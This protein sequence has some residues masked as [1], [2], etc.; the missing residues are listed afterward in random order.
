MSNKEHS[1][2][3]PSTSNANH[4]TCL[5]AK[6]SLDCASF[7]VFWTDSTA[8]LLYVNEAAS[9][10]FGYSRDEFFS[11]NIFDLAPDFKA[12][13]WPRLW[14]KLKIKRRMV[15]QGAARKKDGTLFAGEVT[16]NYFE[17]DGK[18][19][20]LVFFMDITERQSAEEE[21]HYEKSL[22]DSVINALPGIFYFFDEDGRFIFWNKNVE[23]I[24]GYGADELQ[25]LNAF[26]LI[27]GGDR[28]RIKKAIQDVFLNGRATIDTEILSKDGRNIPYYFQG[29]RFEAGGKRYVLGSGI[30]MTEQKWIEDELKKKERFLSDIFNSIQDGISVSDKDMR[31]IRVNPIMEK[32]YPHAQPMIGRKCWE[33]YHGRQTPCEVCPVVKT[34]KTKKTEY[35]VVPW[36]DADGTII[37]WFDLY[38]FPILDEETGEIKG[39]I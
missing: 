16:L 22:M 17:Y 37:G 18:Q 9:T 20:N 29:V 19:Y 8:R 39:I 13:K 4:E 35:E 23:K 27:V 34:L 33:I 10:V 21:L 12:E 7:S 36:R 26:D 3:N 15:I 32:W 38:A 24:S 25:K 6:H 31:V 28:E 5:I 14:E 30:D 1:Q 2:G 11:M